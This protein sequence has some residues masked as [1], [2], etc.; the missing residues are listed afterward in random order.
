VT[1]GK[2]DK[3]QDHQS[4]RAFGKPAYPRGLFRTIIPARWDSRTAAPPERG[5]SGIRLS[6]FAWHDSISQAVATAGMS[7]GG[8]PDFFARD[9]GAPKKEGGLSAN[10]QQGGAI[11]HAL[12]RGDGFDASLAASY[13]PTRLQFWYI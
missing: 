13:F 4:A 10:G 3:T 1:T 6:R 9:D 5:H 2:A 12:K 7:R 11:A 8:Q